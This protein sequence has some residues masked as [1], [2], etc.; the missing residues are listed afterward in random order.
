MSREKETRMVE[1]TGKRARRVKGKGEKKL[2]RGMKEGKGRWKARNRDCFICGTES[3]RRMES[4]GHKGGIWNTGLT[5]NT[6]ME[7]GHSQRSW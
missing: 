7:K 6:I 2:I 1:E 3:L 4:D 5:K